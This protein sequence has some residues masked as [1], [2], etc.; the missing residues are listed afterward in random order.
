MCGRYTLK[1]S[2]EELA[3]DFDADVPEAGQLRFNIAPTQ[4]VA[5][6][7]NDHPRQIRS[8]HW[9]LIPSWAADPSIGNRMINARAETLAER[10]AFRSALQKRRCVVLA[11]GFYEWRKNP[12]GTKTPM[13]IR[14]KS[15]APFGFA[16]L[17]ETWNKQAPPLN[18]CT[19]IT[20][21]PNELMRT[22]HNRMPVI[23][24]AGKI[25]EWLSDGPDPTHLLRPYAADEMEAYAVSKAVN[26]PRHDAPDC[27]APLNNSLG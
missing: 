14:L 21:V 19:I 4:N 6:I 2:R 25:R 9:G 17:W 27:I 20:T 22:I 23:F 18:S 1:R 3:L 7:A 26:N 12:D 13:Y 16:G 8:F 10:P 15:G 5:V 11:D 24:P